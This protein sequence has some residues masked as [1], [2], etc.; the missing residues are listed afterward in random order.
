MSR[1]PPGI[2]ASDAS[3]AA[4]HA[5]RMARGRQQRQSEVAA[6]E[7]EAQLSLVAPWGWDSQELREKRMATSMLSDLEA[8]GLDEDLE[9]LRASWAT[10]RSAAA[11]RIRRGAWSPFDISGQ[12]GS[13][14]RSHPFDDGFEDPMYSNTEMNRRGDIAARRLDMIGTLRKKAAQSPPKPQSSMEGLLSLMDDGGVRERKPRDS[15]NSH[16]PSEAASSAPSYSSGHAFLFGSKDSY[17]PSSSSGHTRGRGAKDW[18]GPLDESSDDEPCPGNLGLVLYK[19]MAKPR[20]PKPKAD[21]N[22]P[23][24]AWEQRWADAFKEMDAAAEAKRRMAAFEEAEARKREWEEYDELR[25]E[26]VRRQQ[27]R[28]PPRAAASGTAFGGSASSSAHP[29]SSPFG[30]AGATFGSRRSSSSQTSGTAGSATGGW[31]QKPSPP[32]PS[33]SK[34]AAKV[35]LSKPAGPEAPKFANQAAYEQ[36]WTRFEAAAK[37]QQSL[38]FVD[39]PFPLSLPS[40]SGAQANDSS[41]DVKKKMRTALLRWHPDKWAPILTRVKDA[42]K[43]R[44][45]EMVKEVT[46]RILAEKER[47]GG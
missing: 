47:F 22:D 12:G 28:R 10:G 14:S 16:L 23:W 8:T 37:G 26:D 4:K 6:K 1:R 21:A 18:R 15:R 31:Q 29:G 3:A 17:C 27:Q 11:Q 44:V 30:G 32:P 20:L 2:A 35:P 40:I 43:E 42:D 19:P 38:G 13:C 7:R 25:Q 33:S 24:A 45:T 9:E 39:I 5:A 46:R 41:A 36:A 34:P